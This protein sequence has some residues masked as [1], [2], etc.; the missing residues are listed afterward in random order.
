MNSQVSI[1]DE[2]RYRLLTY[3]TEHPDA[4]QR[5]LAQHLGVSI[6]KVNYCVRALIEKGWL[7]I[8]NFRSARKKLA[9]LYLLTPKGVEEK[10]SVTSRYLRRKIGEYEALS[11]EIERLTGEV[12]AAG[13]EI[14]DPIGRS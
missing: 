4:T 14:D 5:Q 11:T 13:G 8:Q 10:I 9:Y 2:V 6:G 12:R 3:L 7:K 1:P